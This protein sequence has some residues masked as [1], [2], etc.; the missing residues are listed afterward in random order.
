[1]DNWVVVDTRLLMALDM[2]VMIQ[3]DCIQA[4]YVDNLVQVQH[5]MVVALVECNQVSLEVEAR[6]MVEV[7]VDTLVVV[8]MMVARR[9]QGMMVEH[10]MVVHQFEVH[11]QLVVVNQWQSQDMLMLLVHH[12]VEHL[13]SLVDHMHHM[14]R[15]LVV[16]WPL[17]LELVDQ[18]WLQQVQQQPQHQL[19]WCWH[20]LMH[21]SQLS[22]SYQLHVRSYQVQQYCTMMA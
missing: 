9:Y 19:R 6:M 5:M 13:Q 17:V 2:M 1:M 16:E 14:V 22:E 11:T 15:L 20:S 18:P 4:R 12:L 21:E 8:G 7:V 10:T 3:V